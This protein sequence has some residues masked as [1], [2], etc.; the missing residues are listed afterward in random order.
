MRVV[1]DGGSYGIV[2]RLHPYDEPLSPT[3]WIAWP[4]GLGPCRGSE[5]QT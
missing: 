2:N 3:R 1:E 4:S 5:G